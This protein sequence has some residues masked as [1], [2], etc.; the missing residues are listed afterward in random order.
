M[1]EVLL[2]IIITIIYGI[3]HSILTLTIFKKYKNKFKGKYIDQNV[4]ELIYS[5]ISASIAI[6]IISYS[7]IYIKYQFNNIIDHP[8]L[9]SVGVMIGTIIVIFTYILYKKY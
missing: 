8:L 7:K 2:S 3:I 6:L 9:D 4:S 1:K 5:G